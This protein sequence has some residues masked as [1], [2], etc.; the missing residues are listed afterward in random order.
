MNIDVL[1]K[2]E[3]Y[4]KDILGNDS[5]GHDTFHCLRVKNIALKIASHYD[6]DTNL[7][8][9]AA[10]LHDV[11]DEK[12]FRENELKHLNEFCCLNKIDIVV[13]DKISAIINF[14][15]NDKKDDSISIEAKIVQ[16]AD[17]LDALGA[18]GVARMFAFGG[19][20]GTVLY[21]G[22]NN[23]A[24]AHYYQRIIKL[25]TL[26]NTRYARK[27]ANKRLKYMQKFFSTFNKELNEG[28]YNG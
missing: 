16:D 8:A 21:N 20:K 23:D 22:S 12:I 3:K 1:V 10:L 27:E 14:L 7:I 5:S 13:R 9:I 19:A 24:Y 28:V 26:M 4:V 15:S 11:D 2:A 18:I 6:C 25:P 17:N